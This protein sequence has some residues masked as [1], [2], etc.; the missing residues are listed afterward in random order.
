MANRKSNLNALQ[1]ASRFVSHSVEDM[2]DLVIASMDSA[3][4]TVAARKRRR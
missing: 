2:F 1:R 4:T 3:V